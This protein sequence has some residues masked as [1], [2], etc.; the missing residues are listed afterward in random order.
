M[1]TALQMK[2]PS[3]TTGIGSTTG[4]FSGV[5]LSIS[6][7]ESFSL[8]LGTSQ[9]TLVAGFAFNRATTSGDQELYYFM[10]SATAQVAVAINILGQ[11]Y[12]KRGA[13]GSTIASSSTQLSMNTWYY[14]EFKI[15]FHNTT[16]AIEFRI[17]ENVDVNSSPLNTRVSSNNSA[18]GFTFA[19]NFYGHYTDDFY[20]LDTSGSANNDFLGDVQV[21]SLLPSGAGAH[22]DFT[23]STGSNWQNVDE[24]PSDGD[25]T[26]NESTTT[27]HIDTYAFG[28][29]SASSATV[30]GVMVNYT[31]RKTQAGSRN[32]APVVRTNS[33]DFVGDEVSATA[34]YKTNYQLYEENPDTTDPW[35]VSEVNAAE[36]G[37]K[38]TS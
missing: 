5:A 10:D 37:I 17:N 35:T 24:V 14:L 8:P 2:Y 30:L 3:A 31:A 38:L 15:T 1:S 20:M 7:G 21:Q 33:T 25:T 29:L 19:A 22:T 9:S 13:G 26:Y 11:I 28:N 32:F 16:G 23:P 27:N 4:R 6:G 12:F 18:N 36:F 34:S